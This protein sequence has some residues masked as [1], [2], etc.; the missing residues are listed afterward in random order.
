MR[1]YNNDFIDNLA[2]DVILEVD[3][4]NKKCRKILPSPQISGNIKNMTVYCLLD[5]GSQITA[6]SESFFNNLNKSND[7][8]ALPVSNIIVSTAIGKKTTHVK[9]QVYLELEIE[10]IKIMHIFLIIP[11]LSSD[12]ILGN[13]FNVINGIIIDYW[14]GEVRIRD[15]ILQRVLFERNNSERLVMAKEDNN[16]YIYII[17]LNELNL[18]NVININNDNGNESNIISIFET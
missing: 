17:K 3:P 8:L 11:F 5:T 4:Q 2:N 14:R 7:L 9:S 10:G 6:I 15:K 16:T 12:V 1:Q 13:D 18:E